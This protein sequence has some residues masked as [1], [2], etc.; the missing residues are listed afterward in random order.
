MSSEQPEE[1]F[2][3]QGRFAFRSNKNVL[4]WQVR[5]WISYVEPYHLIIDQHFIEWID[6]AVDEATINFVVDH[7][8]AMPARLQLYL[9]RLVNENPDF[10]NHPQYPTTTGFFGSDEFFG[11]PSPA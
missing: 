8:D 11:Q 9:Q 7:F 6:H 10:Q 3:H 5:G 2:L 4:C 1:R